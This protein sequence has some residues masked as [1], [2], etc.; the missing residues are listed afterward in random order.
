[1]FLGRAAAGAA[2]VPCNRRLVT[3]SEKSG[4]R[5]WFAVDRQLFDQRLRF[6]GCQRSGADTP[7]GI[8]A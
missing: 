6:D 5:F 2:G 1:V 8:S 7:L 3:C 4:R